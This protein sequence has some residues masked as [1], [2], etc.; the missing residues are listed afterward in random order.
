MGAV[1]FGVS[2]KHKTTQFPLSHLDLWIPFDSES[3]L[4]WTHEKQTCTV[5]VWQTHQESA[6]GSY[7]AWTGQQKTSNHHVQGKQ[8]CAYTGWIREQDEES[9]TD[10]VATHLLKECNRIDDFAESPLDLIRLFKQ[11]SG[12]FAGI[13]INA[14]G[15]LSAFHDGACGQQEK[16]QA[17]QR[18]REPGSQGAREI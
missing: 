5:R 14:K 16:Q 4:E 18:D 10:S 2:H 3:T 6:R 12:Q 1:F 13:Y 15:Q 11:R 17:R 7:V 9:L 8:L